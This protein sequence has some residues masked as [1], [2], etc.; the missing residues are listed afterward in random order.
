MESAMVRLL[1]LGYHPENEYPGDEKSR[2]LFERHRAAG[3]EELLARLAQGSYWESY[4]G[5][6]A[7]AVARERGLE[8]AAPPP[9]RTLGL[10]EDDTDAWR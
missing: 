4:E 5:L 6:V 9:R 2:A 10:D 1:W 7:F 3:D 8:V